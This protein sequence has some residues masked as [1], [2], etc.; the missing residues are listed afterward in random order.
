MKIW[1]SISVY[2]FLL[3]GL[4]PRFVFAETVQGILTRLF[5]TLVNPALAI[6]TGLAV[7]VFLWGL[8]KFILRAGS[9]QGRE[10]GKQVMLWGIIGLFVLVSFWG[11]VLM[12]QG[13]FFPG[14]VPSPLSQ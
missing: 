6:L 2:V 13:E 8:V 11:I 10:E 7:L 14:G 4:L 5:N 12:L 9:E 1:R 3:I